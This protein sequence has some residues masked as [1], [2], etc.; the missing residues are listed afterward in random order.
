MMRAAF[1]QHHK[2]PLEILNVPVPEPKLGE[3]LVKIL[4]S[5]CCHTDIH[6]VDGDWNAKSQL[7]LCPGHEGA[8]IVAKVGIAITILLV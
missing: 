7:P 3:I 4:Y 8:G 2:G 1:I 5:G 6:A